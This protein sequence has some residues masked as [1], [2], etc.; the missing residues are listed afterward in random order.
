ML[1]ILS[2]V[3]RECNLAFEHL[4]NCLINPPLLQFPNFNEKF[5]IVTDASRH[6]ISA[7]LSQGTLDDLKPVCYASRTLTDPETRYPSVQLEVL[8]VVWRTRH[9][10]VYI[11][12]QSFEMMTDCKA[13]QWLMELKS[14]NSRLTRWKFELNGYD[15][16]ITHIKGKTNF[17]ADCLSSYIESD[18]KEVKVIRGHSKI[19]YA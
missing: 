15:F 14:P 1:D 17:V 12:Q 18:V 5:Y 6:A 4:K 19:T 7:I 9:Y 10:K 13:L 3:G 16:K 8:A 2:T 11:Q